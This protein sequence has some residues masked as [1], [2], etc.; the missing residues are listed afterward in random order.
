[1]PSDPSRDILAKKRIQS[2]LRKHG[3]ATMRTLEQKISDAGPFP[4]RIDP[5][6]LQ[7]AVTKLAQENVI[8]IETF[9]G[10]SL[11]WIHLTSKP[12]TTLQNRLKEQQHIHRKFESG[13]LNQRIGQTLEIAVFKALKG[14]PFI[15]L[16]NYPDLDSHDD[17]TLYTKEEPP[18]SISGKT[19]PDK[20]RLDFILMDSK[21]KPVG[22]ETKNHREWVYPAH[23]TVRQL[24]LKCVILD[25]VPVLIAR[26]IQYLTFRLL[27]SIGGVVHENFTQLYP[28][29]SRTLAERAKDKNL[30]GYHDIKIGNQPDERLIKFIQVNLPKI[31][32]ERRDKFDTFK[33]LAA[34][35]ANKKMGY[36][37]FLR[38]ISKRSNISLEFFSDEIEF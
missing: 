11:Q 25:A 17:S 10:T 18:A 38:E 24:L 32:P 12:L 9:N 21:G 30:L 26:R 8:T 19:L 31:L 7:N 1:M 27:T 20:M 35:Y 4:Q 3:I 33:D 34:E 14:S 23:D 13:G 5:H 16:G 2:I 36:A 28:E 6:V 22:I 29:S 37:K 15:F